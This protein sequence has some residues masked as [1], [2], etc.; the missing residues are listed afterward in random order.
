M[1]F[2][3]APWIIGRAMSLESMRRCFIGGTSLCLF[4]DLA[5]DSPL[6][7]SRDNAFLRSYLPIEE[8][9]INELP[10]FLRW[11]VSPWIDYHNAAATFLKI[12]E[13]LCARKLI[14]EAEITSCEEVW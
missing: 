11:M 7:C 13:A 10:P 5:G 12:S 1:F 8:M 6:S 9:L 14:L 4:I 3:Q 2:V